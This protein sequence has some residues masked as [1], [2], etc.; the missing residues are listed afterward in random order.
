[1]GGA[2]YSLF[3]HPLENTQFHRERQPWLAANSNAHA[4]KNEGR[5]EW[6]SQW[7]K[8]GPTFQL[9]LVLNDPGSGA[10]FKLFSD[11]L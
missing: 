5:A 11:A 10:E 6:F 7:S 3:A 1:M 2:A 8:T 9:P 4:Q